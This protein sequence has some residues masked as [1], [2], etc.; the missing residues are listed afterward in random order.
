ME[1]KIRKYVEGLFADAPKTKKT[2]EL[3][4]EIYT[5]LI[6]KYNDLRGSGAT[7]EEAYEIV[8]T[9]VGNVDELL[10]S[11]YEKTKEDRMENELLKKKAAKYNSISVTLYI[12][13]PIFII[14]F[15]AVG[16]WMPGLILLLGCIAVATGIKVYSNSIY[17][18]EKE[19]DTLVEEFKE[20][21]AENK[22]RVEKK[23]TYSGVLWLL[24]VVAYFLISFGTGAG[25][26][27]WVIFLIGAAIEQ[28]IKVNTR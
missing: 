6:D 4:Q 1:E 21:K 14:A 16:N 10:E 2:I 27:T 13:S 12:A 22:G 15:V 8:K 17:S 19:D 9:S 25:G 11:L 5:N 23:N 7:E 3:R 26:I 28:L 18:Y 24:I 20:W